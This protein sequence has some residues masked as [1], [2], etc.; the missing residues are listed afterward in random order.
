MLMLSHCVPDPHGL[1][2][3][4]R[5]WQLLSL[6]AKH[7]DVYLLCGLDAPVRLDQWRSIHRLTRHLTIQPPAWPWRLFGP[8]IARDVR[9]LR[10][11]PPAM[12]DLD[13]ALGDHAHRSFD[14]ALTTAPAL[15]RQLEPIAAVHRV[16]DL[17]TPPAAAH[18]KAARTGPIRWR[19]QHRHL[20][21]AHEQIDAQ[22]A[23]QADRVLLAHESFLD[24]PGVSDTTAM[25]LPPAIDLTGLPFTPPHNEL[26]TPT[27]SRDGIHVAI[28]PGAATLHAR[29]HANML[30][31]HL[32]GERDRIRDHA[33]KARL[34]IKFDIVLGE[35]SP[36]LSAADVI[37][38]PDTCPGLGQW[39]ALRSLAL[40]KPLVLP[41]AIAHTLS[42]DSNSSPFIQIIDVQA[43]YPNAIAQVITQFN[44]QATFMPPRKL[45]AS[46]HRL[47]RQTLN[48]FAFDPQPALRLA[49]AA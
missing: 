24:A 4:A 43:D 18:H 17:H 19:W 12:I 48:P 36:A 16:C 39:A 7:F 32:Q 41:R 47:D 37:C 20:A 40:N 25:V 49:Q 21:R 11:T 10:P 30:R 42:L 23:A 46:A 2:E 26:A 44:A 15:W 35:Q 38:V 33:L 27:R 13:L 31:Q 9:D 29:R 45:I 22:A 28:H 1:A 5:A 14:V 3:R 34:K 6:A 8:R